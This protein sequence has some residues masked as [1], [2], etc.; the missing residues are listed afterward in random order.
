MP[1]ALTDPNVDVNDTTDTTTYTSATWT[2]PANALLCLFICSH[3]NLDEPSSVTGHGVTYSKKT[4][5]AISTNSR[6]GLWVAD[7]GGSPTSVGDSA[8]WGTNR[9][10]CQMIPFAL[11]GVDLSGGALAAVVQAP[12]NSG[13]GNT[14]TVTLAGAGAAG[15]RP[16]MGIG[17]QL[18]EAITPRTN[19]AE[20]GDGSIATPARRLE[21]QWRSDTFETTASGTWTT[22]TFDWGAIAAEIKEAAGGA[23]LTW[24]MGWV[25]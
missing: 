9:T 23:V 8:T 25:A 6:I 17:T 13:T 4:S 5:Q 19:W 10:G 14:A 12:V 11:T 1:I 3:T 18:G 15:N 20:I 2:P 16:I 21:A 24:E 7:S 22:A